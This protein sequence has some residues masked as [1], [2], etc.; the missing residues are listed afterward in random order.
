MNESQPLVLVHSLEGLREYC[1]STPNHSR[2]LAENEE[3]M[4][5]ILLDLQYGSG[6]NELSAQVFKLGEDV[7]V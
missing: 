1:G 5:K 3:T 4:P 2:A 6:A 7:L